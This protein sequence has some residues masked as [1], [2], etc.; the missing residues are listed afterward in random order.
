MAKW[1]WIWIVGLV[2]CKGP[3]SVGITGDDDD[4]ATNCEL[5]L[6][7][8]GSSPG[9][10]ALAEIDAV[11]GPFAE[12]VFRMRTLAV[13][14][15]A[16]S[17]LAIEGGSIAIFDDSGQAIASGAQL[18]GS[19]TSLYASGVIESGETTLTLQSA[20]PFC[21]LEPVSVTLSALSGPPDLAGH[22][23]TVFPHFQVVQA[24][25]SD[26]SVQ[27]AL[28]PFRYADRVGEAA[29]VII[30]AHRSPAEW[31]ADNTLSPANVAVSTTVG[32][33]LPANVVDAWLSDLP[34][35][36]GV[37]QAWD[38]VYDFGQDGTLDPGDLIDGFDSGGLYTVI[39]LTQPGPYTPASFEYSETFWNTMRVYAPEN[40]TADHPL[41]VISHGNGHD[42]TWY[43]Y[44]GNHLASWG[45][46]VISHRNDTVPGVITAAQ[47]TLSNTE[48]FIRALP[49]M[50]GGLLDGKV[51]TSHITWIGHSRGGEG[52]VIAYDWLKNGNVNSNY[53]D[54]NDVVLVS[55]IAPTLFEGP[56]NTNPNDVDYHLISGSADGDVTG[57]IDSSILQY[58][59]IFMRGT[60]DHYVTYVQGASHNDFNCCGDADGTWFTVQGPAPLIGRQRAQQVAKSYFLAL[61]EHKIRGNEVLGE[62]L[63]RAP[64]LF[65]PFAVDSFVATQWM[66]AQNAGKFIVDNFQI[67]ASSDTSASGG[68][69][70]YSVSNLTEAALDDGNSNLTWQDGDP[71]NGMSWAHG[72]PM[73]ERGVVFDY[74]GDAWLEFEIVALERDWTDAKWLSFR[75]CQGTR[76]PRTVALN[77]MLSFSATLVDGA[78]A[79]SSIDFA[80]YGRLTKPYA[81]NDN[82]QGT[83]WINEFQTIRIRVA[84]FASNGHEIDL[85]N[86]TALRFDFGPSYG[87]AEGRVG[88]DDIEVLR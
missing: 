71:M 77:Q 75:A 85:S 57:G 84:D 72:D 38:V 70:S 80:N 67:E 7:V 46:V 2:G 36:D 29:D 42:Y 86:I 23:L 8:P 19:T 13:T 43:D 73:P 3:A 64:E 50:G 33:D 15:P 24:F 81:R 34:T 48:A 25:N 37:T 11:D 52:V 41:V 28:D 65:H 49:T 31:A 66:P 4:D 32:A 61:L 56:D 63:G 59:R 53:F 21:A 54:A 39:D 16:G 22:G 82:G 78:G 30:V 14:A 55:S 68:A 35:G 79:T 58:Y 20:S 18:P 74:D 17:I 1:H 9:A 62:Y 88:M 47:T 87:S 40:P 10:K 45:Y 76:H 60:G 83:G 69:V 6:S 5:A 51:D 27:T 12:R 26:D 44:L